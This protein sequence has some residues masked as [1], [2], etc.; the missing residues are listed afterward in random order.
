V[1]DFIAELRREVLDAHARHGRR[2]RLHRRVRSAHPRAW[3]PAAILATAVVATSLAALV[4]AARFLAGPAPSR[5]HVVGVLRIGGTPVDAAFGDGSLWVTDFNGTV[6]RIDPGSRRVLA[7]IDVH[8]QP[9]AIAV[10][11]GSV[12]VRGPDASGPAGGP[13]GS[14]LLQ[15]D[16]GT[17]RV[18][19]RVA[20]GGGSGL[21][22][23][24]D[25]VWAPRRFTMR[26][27]I[28][29]IDAATGARTRPIHLPNV[30]G[31][32]VGADALW[33]IQHDGT[34][35]R[36]DPSAD[37]IARR[38]LQLAPSD[39][40]GMSAPILPDAGGAWLLSTT[41]A[42][43]LRVAGG[44]VVRQI[45]VDPSVRPLLARAL[46]GLWI[47]SGDNLGLRNR[48]SRID[49][50]TGHVTATLDLGDQRP[51]A[52]VA[53]NDALFVVTA[54]GNVLLIRS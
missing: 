15:I 37:R 51:K 10:G 16:P 8:G 47:A 11:A 2:G 28:D 21:A 36:I 25:A 35:A 34:V 22:V 23:A 38:W 29:R 43:I 49:P 14:R 3:S 13:L 26:E 52:L 24:A 39:A 31:V 53:A 48:V 17:N 44:R 40:G 32:A 19:A 27:G 30:D 54:Q 12:W 42:A 33:V 1:S 7:R 50:D 5:P 9:E 6:V 46:D 41:K 20:L 18:V 4:I 45:A